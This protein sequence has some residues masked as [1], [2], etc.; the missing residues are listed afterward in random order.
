MRVRVRNRRGR[1]GAL[2]PFA[3]L[4]RRHQ[5][6]LRFLGSLGLLCAAFAVGTVANIALRPGVVEASS[7]PFAYVANEGGDTLTPIDTSTDTAGT[8]I[9]VGSEPIGVAITPGGSTVYVAN[10]VS[11]TL[12]PIDTSTDTAGTPITVLSGPSGIAI[13]P[14]GTTVYVTNADSNKVTPVN[15]A[16]DTAGTPIAVGSGPESIAITPDGTTAYVVNYGS[17]TVT[18]VDTSSNTAGTP[19]TVGSDPDAIAITPDGSMAYVANAGSDT[20]TPI[21]TSTDTAGTPITVGTSPEGIAITPDG[22]TAYVANFGSGTVTPIDTSTDTAGTPIAVG[23]SPFAV[24]TTPDGTTAYVSD[25]G[26]D[27]VTPIDTATNTAG[28][29]ITVGSNPR[30][31]AITPDQAPEAQLSVTPAAAGSPTSFDASASV[32]PSSPIASYAWNFGDGH[33]ATTTSPTTTHTY[34]S[35]GTFTAT[36]T[37]TDTAGTSTTQVFTGQTV[38]RNGGPSAVASQSFVVVNCMANMSC[39]GTVADTS[40]NISVGGTSTTDASL[41]VSLGEQTLSCGT[42]PAAPEQVTTYSTTTFTAS[43]LTGTL[44][45][46]GETGTS[47][48]KVCFASSTPFTDKQGNSVTSGDLPKCV[49]VGNVAPCIVS[50]SISGGNLV[51]TLSLPPGDPR[52][53]APPVLSSFSPTEGAVGAKVKIKGGPFAGVTEIS[54]NGILTQFK[55]KS[56]GTKITAIVPAG[57]TSGPIT[58]VARGGQ[59]TSKTDFT[60]EG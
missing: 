13:T 27:T 58:V 10:S 16:T 46:N 7:G 43:S 57:A 38:S 32:A 14:D 9:T 25:L 31:I 53:W 52:F 34:S 4:A 1:G 3:G 11:A 48:F 26:T 29:P 49:A 8:P 33:T 30:G 59:V 20:V 18:P 55:V 17:G 60:V 47:G 28:T 37:E 45:V 41:S 36:V 15:T 24:A 12:T 22:N 21:D 5:L 50:T 19:I 56:S 54:F 51:A 35:S 2:G 42:A 6:R 40:Q 39:S 23:G 44:T